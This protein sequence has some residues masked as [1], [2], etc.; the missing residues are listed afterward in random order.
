M[1]SDTVTPTPCPGAEQLEGPLCLNMGQTPDGW[2]HYIQ[3]ASGK[4]RYIH[5]G[6]LLTVQ[7]KDGTWL[8]GRYVRRYA[9]MLVGIREKLE[10][11]ARIAIENYVDG[12]IPAE[13]ILPLGHHVRIALEL[14]E[15]IAQLVAEIEAGLSNLQTL[16]RT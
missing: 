4:R 8:Q 10:P 11:Q 2:R 5:P 1:S 14:E 15:E 9:P 13:I 6:E 7:R 16:R 12:H 3:L